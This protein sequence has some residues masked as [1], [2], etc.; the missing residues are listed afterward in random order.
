MLIFLDDLKE[1]LKSTDDH[2]IDSYPFH[3]KQMDSVK[4]LMTEI[5]ELV[6]MKALTDRDAT[7]LESYLFIVMEQS[8]SCERI[9]N[10]PIPLGFL[11]HI[12]TSIY[13]YLLSL[14]FGLFYDLGAISTF[15]IMTIY[16][17][18]GGIEIISN[19]IENPFAGDPNDL[20]V[21]DLIENIK[22]SITKSEDDGTLR[23]TNR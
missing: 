16:Y 12:K 18:I 3:K 23:E 6:R 14:P 19:E 10:T 2:K 20:P 11:M 13:I 1:Y 9:K 22:K 8:N 21:D 5:K 4:Y 15:M 17:V 7:A